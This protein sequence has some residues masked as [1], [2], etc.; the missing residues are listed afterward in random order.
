MDFE[1]DERKSIANKR[2]HGIDFVEAQ[3]LWDDPDLIQ[4]TDGKSLVFYRPVR[5]HT[6]IV[7]A[8]CMIA[9]NVVTVRASCNQ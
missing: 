5:K 3:S 6:D 9:G 8:I 1:F 7:F 2:K 4:F